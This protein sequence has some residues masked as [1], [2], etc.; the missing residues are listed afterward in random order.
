MHLSCFRRE[1]AP[2]VAQLQGAARNCGEDGGRL[3]SELEGTQSALEGSIPS[4]PGCFGWEFHVHLEDDGQSRIPSL[5]E[6]FS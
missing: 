1:A 2:L 4:E 3:G 5:S 6:K